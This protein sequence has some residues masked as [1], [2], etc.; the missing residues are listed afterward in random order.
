MNVVWVVSWC[1]ENDKEATVT[2]FDN[3][4]NAEWCASVFSKQHHNVSVDECRVYTWF[5]GE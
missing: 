2:V 4:D 3:R 5:T 1:D